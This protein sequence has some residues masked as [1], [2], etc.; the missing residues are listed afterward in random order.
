MLWFVCL[1]TL[2]D[3][4]LAAPLQPDRR[5]S[6]HNRYA[7][8]SSNEAFTEPYQTIQIA[9]A[10]PGI[11]A[12]IKVQLGD[13]VDTGDL[14]FE[15]DMSVLE[16]SRRLAQAKANSQARLKAAEVEHESKLKR[17]QQLVDLVK[18]NAGSPE[19]VERA[20]TQSEIARQGVAAIAEEKAQFALETKRIE[21]QIEQRRIRSPIAGV[22]IEIHKKPGEYVSSNA[23]QLATV[24]QLQ[25]LRAVFHLPTRTAVKLQRGDV[26]Q[27]QLTE[28]EQSAA[29]IVEYVAPITKADSGRVRVDVR[30]DNQLGQYRSGVR[31]RMLETIP[32]QSSTSETVH[33]R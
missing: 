6:E 27:I 33:V 21:S 29:A 19:E 2:T 10:E 32:Q 7:S 14:L 31:C 4:S 15:M 3:W 30:I 24:V 26:V 8:A 11:I 20:K 28:T 1:S 18:E 5:N 22:V 13:M 12:N 9:S 25:T 23:P 16:A 17:Y